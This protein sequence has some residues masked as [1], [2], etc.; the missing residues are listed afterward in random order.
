MICDFL[1]TEWDNIVGLLSFQISV[2]E[3]L[4]TFFFHVL[5]E[6]LLSG[7]D[8]IE[9]NTFSSTRVAQADYGLEHLVRMLNNLHIKMLIKIFVLAAKIGLVPESIGIVFIDCML[10]LELWV[11]AHFHCCRQLYLL[12]V[13][14]IVCLLLT[15]AQAIIIYPRFC[16]SIPRMSQ[17]CE[18]G[19][20]ASVLTRCHNGTAFFPG[21]CLCVVCAGVCRSPFKLASVIPLLCYVLFW[22]FEKYVKEN[23]WKYATWIKS[24]FKSRLIL[25]SKS[26]SSAS[27]DFSRI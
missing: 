12:W 5:Q 9:T 24:E 19:C 22:E 4:E 11:V 15:K 2:L 8:I 14:V 17:F 20:F 23:T 6:Y 16:L 3:V 27:V 1:S 26:C 18:Q 25:S 10:S 21:W 7:A 13:T